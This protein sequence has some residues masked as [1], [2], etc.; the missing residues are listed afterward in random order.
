MSSKRKQVQESG[1]KESEAVVWEEEAGSGVAVP[2]EQCA[3]SL[4]CA[5]STARSVP[6]LYKLPDGPRLRWSSDMTNVKG[7]WELQL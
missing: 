2:L 1:K 3:I 4:W 5:Q 7:L 6:S